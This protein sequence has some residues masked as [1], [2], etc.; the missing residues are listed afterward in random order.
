[1]TPML[2]IMAS[3][4]SG[5]KQSSFESIATV[6][7]TG[8]GASAT[9][10]FTSIPATYK[11]L[12]V[13]CLMADATG[14]GSLGMF[15]T[16]NSIATYPYHYLRG[17]GTTATAAGAAAP[18]NGYFNGGTIVGSATDTNLY[19]VAIIDFIDY[20]STSKNKTVRVFGGFDNNSTLGQVQL[21]SGLYIDSA[22]AISSI[23]FTAPNNYWSSKTTFSLYGIKG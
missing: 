10:S 22:T 23:T 7:G 6:T 11:H 20:A 13:R 17:N 21:S 8:T 14:T 2:G 5:S 1:M 15:F 16:V 9:L 3:S 19:G 18:G 4:I 12:Q